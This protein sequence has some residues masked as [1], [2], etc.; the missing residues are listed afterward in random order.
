M[1]QSPY[2]GSPCMGGVV[3]GVVGLFPSVDL[4]WSFVDLFS[5]GS[6]TSGYWGRMFWSL[7]LLIIVVFLGL[8]VMRFL[9]LAKGQL[10]K[11]LWWGLALNSAG[12]CITVERIRATCRCG[13]KMLYSNGVIGR[14]L[15]LLRRILGP[16]GDPIVKCE[17]NPGHS[18]R[19][20]PAERVEG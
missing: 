14:K 5:A 13:A 9:R 7:I 10:R 20:D 8:L 19:V 2:L 16:N 12:R 4:V 17:R 3:L 11:P 1:V 18:C 15:N 6:S